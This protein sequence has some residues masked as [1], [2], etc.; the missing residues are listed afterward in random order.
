MT[1][2]LKKIDIQP[3]IIYMDRPGY[4]FGYGLEAEPEVVEAILGHAVIAELGVHV[5]EH[6][7]VI[8]DLDQIPE[9]YALV[10]INLEAWEPSECPLC[11]KGIPLNTNVGKAKTSM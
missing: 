2:I 11:K 1:E 10:N 3:G 8:Q 7:L 4:Y 5:V 6:A 9:L